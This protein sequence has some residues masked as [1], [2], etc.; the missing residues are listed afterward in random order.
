MSVLEHL[1]RLSCEVGD[2]AYRLAILGEGNTS[3]AEGTFFWV[4]ASGHRLH[5]IGPDGFARCDREALSRAVTS[6]AAMDDHA[7]HGLLVSQR[8]PKPSVEAFMHAWLLGLP[9]VEFVGHVHGEATLALLCTEMGRDRCRQR[10]FPDE[11]V[12][13]GAATLWIPYVDP[14]LALAREIAARCSSWMEAH[15]EPP[16]M[17]ALQNHGTIA[18]GPSPGVVAAALQMAEK[19]ARIVIAALSTGSPLVPLTLTEV[20]RIA[21][22]KDEHERQ[23]TIWSQETP[24]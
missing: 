20:N 3:G 7:V 18:L 12:L 24:S 23:A 9:G 11:V 8:G 2:P 13:C 22:R 5:G 10:F 16:R 15:G 17:I 19:A 14:G 6:G 4:K 1:I 21:G